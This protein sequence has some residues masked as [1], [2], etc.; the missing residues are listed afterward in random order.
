[1]IL[2]NRSNACEEGR[3]IAKSS[4]V[5]PSSHSNQ[6]LTSSRIPTSLRLSSLESV[7]TQIYWSPVRAV[8]HA[9]FADDV[10]ELAHK[11]NVLSGKWMFFASRKSLSR[12]CRLSYCTWTD[13]QRQLKQPTLS[14]KCGQRLSKLLQ[15]QTVH[16]LK[17]VSSRLQKLLQNPKM[18][19]KFKL[20]F[21]SRSLEHH[22]E[23]L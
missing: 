12:L 5:L 22:A 9:K 17:P 1:M 6:S 20:L 16:S 2:G 15:M 10:K 4:Q 13:E 3:E 8:E 14:I 7:L 11:Y 19:S 18:A 23:Q 21:H